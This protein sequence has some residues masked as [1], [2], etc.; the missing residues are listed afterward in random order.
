MISVEKNL[1]FDLLNSKMA[2]IQ[3]EINQILDKW[4]YTSVDKLLNDA[5]I[6]ILEEA[7]DD[8][9]CLKNLIDKREQLLNYK[10]EWNE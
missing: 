1:L 8:A 4:H 9:I 10:Y 5:K 2:L 3:D 6:G 7:E